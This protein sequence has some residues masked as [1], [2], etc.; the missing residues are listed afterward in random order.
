[1][2]KIGR[3]NNKM[4]INDL[5]WAGLGAER[6]ILFMSYRWGGQ[7][8][9]ESRGNKEKETGRF[10][11]NFGWEKACGEKKGNT[12]KYPGGRGKKEGMENSRARN[13]LGHPLV[14]C[15]G[16]TKQFR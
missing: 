1:V 13:Q 15:G 7:K 11:R 5:G 9:D 4:K 3:N 2:D 16:K 8:H 12:G 6:F 14:S 10:L